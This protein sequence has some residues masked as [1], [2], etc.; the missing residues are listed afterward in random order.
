MM[1]LMT[2]NVPAESQVT[3][4]LSRQNPRG[5]SQRIGV[6]NSHKSNSGNT[7]RFILH[8]NWSIP[9]E[10]NTSVELTINKEVDQKNIGCAMF[11]PNSKVQ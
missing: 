7:K 9:M 6:I 1:R 3:N 2:R 10:R 11:S 4:S 8:H 5:A